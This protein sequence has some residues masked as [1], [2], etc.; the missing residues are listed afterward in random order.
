MRALLGLLGWRT[1]RNVSLRNREKEEGIV[2]LKKRQEIKCG[3][4]F[5][6]EAMERARAGEKRLGSADKVPFTARSLAN[7]FSM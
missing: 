1:R 7:S 6:Y 3:D 5:R 2:D 4:K